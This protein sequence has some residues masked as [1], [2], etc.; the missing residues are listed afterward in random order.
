MTATESG[1]PLPRLYLDERQLMATGLA[2]ELKKAGDLQ[3]MA[4]WHLSSYWVPVANAI[5][6]NPELLDEI[7]EYRAHQL[8]EEG[9][10]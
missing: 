10:R 8:N 1:A 4:Q 2:V 7:C 5:L 9:K 6:A 3:S